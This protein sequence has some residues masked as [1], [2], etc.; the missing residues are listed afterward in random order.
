M[1]PAERIFL[2]RIEIPVRWVDMDAYQHVNNGKYFDY[3]SEARTELFRFFGHETHCQ[4]IVVHTECAFKRPYVYPATVVLEQFIESIGPCS[5]VLYYRFGVREEPD[6]LYAEG[7]AKI[8]CFD[9]KKKRMMKV[10]Q[11]VQQVLKEGYSRYP[12]V[13]G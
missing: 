4:F 2:N 11:Q 9:P 3:M 13:T 5:F 6:V 12:E 8:A 1:Q 7:S 10:P